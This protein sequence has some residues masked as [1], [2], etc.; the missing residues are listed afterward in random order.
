[1]NFILHFSFFLLFFYSIFSFPSPIFKCI[2]QSKPVCA[3]TFFE[4]IFF[5]LYLAPLYFSSI[6]WPNRR[7]SD[8][9]TQHC[10]ARDTY[11]M[12][13]L[14]KPFLPVFCFVLLFFLFCFII[15]IFQR[16]FMLLYFL[17]LF[18]ACVLYQQ[19]SR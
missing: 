6:N 15:I 5:L 11:T 16:Y 12:I 8:S 7:K 9:V 2:A 3:S 14:A 1:M 19:V 17:L 13:N 4:A 10:Q 18:A